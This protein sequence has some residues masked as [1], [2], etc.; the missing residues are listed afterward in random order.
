MDSPVEI[1]F[2]NLQTSPA[3]EADIRERVERLDKLYPRLIGCRV[4]V[5]KQHRHHQTGNS[6]DVHIE[7]DVPGEKL[8][9]TQDAHHVR[10]KFAHADDLGLAVREAFRAAQRRLL[11]FKHKQQGVV[12]PHDEPFAGTVTELH[13]QEDHGFLMT[14]EGTLLYFHRNS[15]MQRDFDTLTIGARV[16]FVET[17]GDTGPLATKVWLAEGVTG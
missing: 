14:H 8:M 9:V 15:L 2:H 11:D 3:L 6:F 16:H 10:Q 7:L 4:S 17:V 5:E 12:K 13:P 1:V